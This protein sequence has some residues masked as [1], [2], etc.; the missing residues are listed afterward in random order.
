MLDP[1]KLTREGKVGERAEEESQEGE[2]EA[3]NS[4][5]LKVPTIGAGDRVGI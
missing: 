5:V 2:G 1:E 3:Y 4:E